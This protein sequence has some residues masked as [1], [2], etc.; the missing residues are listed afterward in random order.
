MTPISRP[1]GSM[2][3]TTPEVES[4]M[5]RFDSE[6][7]CFVRGDQKRLLD[8]LVIVERLAHAH[9][10]HIGDGTAVALRA[11]RAARPRHQ[12]A[13][14]GTHAAREIAEPLA[15]HQDLAEDFAGA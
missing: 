9:H 4:V 7:P 15:R 10:H 14:V 12:A 11:A 5:R 2:N 6:M 8:V 3:G 1:V 13:I